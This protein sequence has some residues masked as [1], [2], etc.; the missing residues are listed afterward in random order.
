MFGYDSDKDKVSLFLTGEVECRKCP[1]TGAVKVPAEVDDRDAVVANLDGMQLPAGWRRINNASFDIYNYYEDGVHC[2]VCVGLWAE[3]HAAELKQYAEKQAKAAEKEVQ[4]V[5]KAV[6]KA[7]AKE[8][9]KAAKKAEK[10]KEKAAKKR[11]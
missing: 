10:A 7:E 9:K 5:A 3:Q 4:R 1:A 6:E 11:K 8:A 2:P